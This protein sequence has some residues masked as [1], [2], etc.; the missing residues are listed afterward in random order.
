VTKVAVLRV[1]VVE[2]T[3]DKRGVGNP[4]HMTVFVFSGEAFDGA[5]QDGDV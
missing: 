2:Q 4:A 1:I 5:H 3:R